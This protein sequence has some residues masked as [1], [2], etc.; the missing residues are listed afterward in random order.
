MALKKEVL[1]AACGA[2]ATIHRVD[3]VTLNKQAN[4]TVATVSSFYNTAALSQGL[5]PLAQMAIQ[6]DGLPAKGQDAWEFAE[7]ALVAAA[8]DGTTVDAVI[9]QYGVDRHVFA[10]AEILDV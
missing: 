2:P 9:Q 10:G 1:I 3:S 7:T 4:S 5:Q 6:L 8:P